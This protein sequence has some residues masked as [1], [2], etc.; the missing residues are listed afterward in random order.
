[1]P[2]Y[3]I[4]SE[5]SGVLVRARSNVHDTDTSIA[6]VAGTIDADPNALEERGA[7]VALGVDMT[8][9][10]AGDWLKN[11]K[12]RKDL[13]LAAHPRAEFALDALE[14]IE[15]SGDRFTATARGRLSWRGR[16]IEISATGEGEVTATH[17]DATA[18]FD[19]DV[20][21][22]G[23]VPPKILMFKIEDVVSVEVRV[24]ARAVG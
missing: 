17:I 14:D 6:G 2:R 1:M 13:D 22:L 23:V 12:L 7:E 15:R 9:A 20:T 24:I 8:T 18:R 3:Q 5:K 11:R 16:K 21:T 10:D 19:L 4:D